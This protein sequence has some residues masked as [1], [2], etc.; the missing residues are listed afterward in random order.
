MSEQT[1]SIPGSAWRGYQTGKSVGQDLK[2]LTAIGAELLIILMNV[3][4]LPVEVFLRTKFGER[5]VSPAKV[6]VTLAVIQVIGPLSFSG[7]F[8]LL[9]D[10][11]PDVVGPA[12]VTLSVLF[13]IAFVSVALVHYA[14]AR[15]RS[16]RGEM[17]HSQSDG[18]PVPIW[19]L[20]GLGKKGSGE[21]YIRQIGEPVLVC[22]AGVLGSFVLGP[23]VGAFIFLSGLVLAMKAAVMYAKGRAMIL[24]HLDAQIENEVWTSVL[25]GNP[26]ASTKG[27]TVRGAAPRTPAEQRTFE[28]MIEAMPGGLREI[29]EP[30]EPAGI[31]G[32]R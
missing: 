16:A 24:D 10:G 7:V 29:M 25:R 11:M 30:K 3:L 1:P 9:V 15:A 22:G 5:Y 17:W 6:L 12:L 26:D 20:P 2:R 19:H 13:S 27:F 18:V 23:P 31:G 28:S 4:T 8:M 14:L 21:A 32:S